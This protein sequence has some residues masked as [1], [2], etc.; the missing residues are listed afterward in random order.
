MQDTNLKISPYFD[1]FDSSKN[2]QKILFKPGYSVQTRELNSLQSIFQN[3]I[4]RFGQHVFKDGSLV[5]PGNLNYNLTQ[6]CVLV[7]SFINGISVEYNRES[8]IGKILT[9][10][11][12]GVKAKVVDTLSQEQSEKDTITFYITYTSGGIFEDGVQLSEFKN[13]ETLVDENDLPVAITTVQN[14]SAYAGST[15][16]INAGVYFVRGF[17]VEVLPQTIILE[18]YNSKPSYK[19]GLQVVESITTVEEDETLYD[20]SLGSTNYASPGADR[21]K[22]DLNLI[23]QNLLVTENSDFIEL[24]RFDEGKITQSTTAETSVYN[25][26]EKNLARRTFDESGSYTTTPYTIK[27]REALNDGENGGVYL[28]NE[29]LYDGRTIV[30]EAPTGDSAPTDFIL[31]KDYYAVELSEGKAYVDGFEIINERKQYAV[32]PKPRKFKSL[33]NQGLVLDIGS[34][35]KLDSSQTI[36]GTVLF[37]DKVFL[38]DEDGTIIGRARSLGMSEGFHLYVADVT[39]YEKITLSGTT[40]I[41]AGDYIVGN[42]SGATAYIESVSVNG[43]NKDVFLRQVSGYFIKEETITPSRYTASALPKITAITREVLE[44]VR[45]VEK[46]VSSIVEFSASIKLDS[47]SISGSTF[48]ISNDNELTGTNTAFDFELSPKSKIKLPGISPVEVDTVTADKVVLETNVTNGTYYNLTKLVCK[49]YT[50]NNGLTTRSSLYRTKSSSNY[51]HN[52][53][54]CDTSYSTDSDKKFTIQ[55]PSGTVIDKNSII[56]T[57]STGIV[58]SPVINQSSS[59]TVSVTT[60]L[61]PGTNVTVYYKLSTTPSVKKKEKQSYKF[62]E[63]DKKKNSTNNVYGTRINDRDISL[64]YPDVLKVHAIHQATKDGEAVTDLFD[65]LVL[66]DT[67]NLL[68]GDLITLGTI[69]ARVIS[70]NSTKV[71]IKYISNSKFQSG[72]NLAISIEVPTNPNAV[73]LFIKESAYGRYI[74]ITDDFKFV[75]NDNE[76]FYNVSKL[77][78]KSSAAEP[79][80]DFVVVFDY[81]SHDNLSNDFYSIESYQDDLSSGDLTYEEIPNSYNYIPMADLID[82]RYYVKPSTSSSSGTI[83]NPYKETATH[84][85]FDI[86][87]SSFESNQKVPYP[88]AFFNLNYEFYLGRIDKVYLVS[89]T[90]KY[91]SFSGQLRVIQGADSI[92]PIASSDDSKGLLLS[93]ITLAP[94]LKSVSEAS[95]KL[96]KT[97]NY[98]MRDIGKLEDRLS[99][100]EKY[101][102]LSLLEVNTNNL[103]ILDEEGRN[104]FKNGFVVD[105][106]TSTDVADQSNPDYTASL[107]LDKNIVRPYPYVNNTG[108]DYSSNSTA[109]KNDTY[110]TLP[111]TE[112]AYID[113]PYSSR[114]ENLMPYEIFSYVGS[115]EVTPKKDIWYDT[116]REI[117]EGQNINLVDSYTALFDMVVPGGQ[118]WGNWERGAGGTRRVGGGRN[119]TDIRRGTQFEV[120]SLNFDI[121]SGDT[122]QDITD[123]R[124]SRSRIINL[125]VTSLKPNTNFYFYIN[126]SEASD[127]IYPKLLR[128][129]S[130]HVGTFVLGETVSITPI[131]DDD[132]VRIQQFSPLLATIINPTTI[133]NQISSGDFGTS[134]YT[135]QTKV[136]AID[137]IRSADGSDINPTLIGSKYRIIGNSSGARADVTAT[138]NLLSNESGNLKAFVL[139]PQETYETG[140]ITLSLSDQKDNYQV[141]G[142]TSSYATGIYYSQGTEINVTSTVTTL[143]VPELTATAIQ[144]SRTRFIPDPPPPPPPP[145]RRRP[146]RRIDPLAQSFFIDEQGGIFVTSIDLFFLT[147]DDSSPVIVDIRTVENGSPTSNIVPGTTVSVSAS[148]IKTS[149]DASVATEF[150]FKNPI[151]L[152]SNN[153]YAFVVRTT[154]QNY[155]LWVSRLGETDVTTGLKIDK[156]PYVGVLYKSSNQSIWTPDQFEDIKFV[157]NRAQFTTNQTFTAILP[158]K[159]IVDQELINNPFKFTKGSSTIRV[160]QPNHGMHQSQNKVKISNVTSDTSNAQLVTA[161]TASATSIS[162]YDITGAN[163]T[164]A[165]VEGWNTINNL[166]VSNEN[167]GFIK[168]NDE[169]ISYTGISNNQLT[170]CTRGALSTTAAPHVKGEIVQCFHLNGIPLNQLNTTHAVTKAISLDEYEIVVSY[171]ANSNKQSGRTGV[172]ASRNIQYESL[173]P[174]F[175]IFTP[176]N[177]D[178]NISITTVS[179]TSIGN[180]LQKSFVNR[181]AESIE[182]NVENI[183]SEPKLILSKPNVDAFQ[184]GNTGSLTAIVSMST[185]VDRLSPVIDLEGSSIITISNRLNK[186]LDTD[187]NLDISSELL[188]SGGKH[189]SYI[190]K[191]VVLETSSTSVKV[192]FDAIRNPSNDIKVFVKIKGDSTPGSFDDMNYVEIPAISYPTSATKKEFRA[193]DYEIKSLREFQ[194]FSIK[195]VMIGDDQS[196]VPKIRNFRALA[197]AL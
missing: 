16:T 76:N 192:L 105:S 148:D 9:G 161:I 52:R 96:E 163:F 129:L 125:D 12:S 51:I 117:V 5:I 81:F 147:K 75:R 17:F 110:V 106:F 127:I 120:D 40:N 63:V 99:N 139:L 112:V 59:N 195:V 22:I 175:N 70:I 11:T 24:L 61:S 92:D 74:D 154:N 159:Q 186:E 90:D 6:K 44:N 36:K 104:R 69:K 82:F 182:N 77:V 15:V 134:G 119:I 42:I 37:N 185:E 27:V 66:N 47:V 98:T 108:V 116:Q 156:Q 60:S 176:Y 29:V 34:H 58:S 165:T 33:E 187:G 95:I 8:L 135:N 88:S 79:Q 151:Y 173:T 93:T 18:Q 197:L 20:N 107:D 28:P 141:A 41:V 196:S 164:P 113:Q 153:D 48:E 7:Q 86:Y 56:V 100:V 68:V 54:I 73:G 157:L 184:S 3:Q 179:G 103:N 150:K 149:L 158:N 26:L 25:E 122:I 152:S 83:S 101:T 72:L 19:V 67:S 183:L 166:Q 23:K 91:G 188:P 193:F 126:D 172:L 21:L 191:K 43:G 97:R 133:T 13:N 39:I 142:L 85:V 64:K 124:F 155:N 171:A 102:S 94:Y 109:F 57:T 123:V 71:Y 49:L 178:S 140:D 128:D 115:M 10:V 1:D 4:E 143:E 138:Q 87:Q 114:V 111:F 121:E 118:V 50:A 174:K 35:F 32:V 55:T 136:L 80:N 78:R 162:L 145:P 46:I 180:S 146:A 14:A 89:D 160:F 167:P 62:L 168:I 38:K 131:N 2:Y 190:T 130:N 181:P 189:S 144:D 30:N 31:G 84:S 194:E 45:T 170:G 137:N 177:T 65:S 132:L 169:I 53:L